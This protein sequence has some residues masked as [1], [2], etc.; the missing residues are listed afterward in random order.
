LGRAPPE[1]GAFDTA[2]GLALPVALVGSPFPALVFAPALAVVLLDLALAIPLEPILLVPSVSFVM[3]L[4]GLASLDLVLPFAALA[5]EVAVAE[6]PEDFLTPP[7]DF[8]SGRTVSV[9]F[10][11]PSF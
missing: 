3:G 2:A 9:S 7:P 6:T 1:A 5:L 10:A 8:D 4:A 11:A